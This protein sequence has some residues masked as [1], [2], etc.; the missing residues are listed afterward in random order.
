MLLIDLF[1][2]R[3]DSKFV[4]KPTGYTSILYCMIEK[5][6]NL[7]FILKQVF[8]KLL[9]TSFY[10]KLKLVRSTNNSWLILC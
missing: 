5:Y 4:S 8:K 7:S 6:F 1:D 10:M 9:K 3:F 2:N